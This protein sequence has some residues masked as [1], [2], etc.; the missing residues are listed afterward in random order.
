MTRNWIAMA[1][2]TLRMVRPGSAHRVR[3][4]MSPRLENLEHRLSLSTFS[5]SGVVHSFRPLNPQPL[6]PIVTE[7]RRALNPQPLPPVVTGIMRPLNPQPLPPIVT[8]LRRALNPQPLP[9]VVTEIMR[10]LNPQPLPPGV[11]NAAFLT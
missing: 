2:R 1:S 5:A 3:H 8:D 4:C 10:P 6:P 7:L 11:D 9:P